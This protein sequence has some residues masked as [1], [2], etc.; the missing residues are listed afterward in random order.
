[1]SSTASA[2]PRS[3]RQTSQIQSGYECF[4]GPSGSDASRGPTPSATRR[5]TAFVNGTARSSRARRTSSTDSFTAAYC[6]TPSRY[7]SWYAPSLSA[8]RT[9]A[10]SLR[11]GR[12][13]SVSIAWSSVRTRC[14][15]PNA[16][17][18]A[19]ARSRASRPAEALRSALSA[20]ASSSKTRRSTSYAAPRAGEITAGRAGTR[21][22]SCAACPRAAP[23]PGRALRPPPGRSRS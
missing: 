1:M 6:G 23:R 22:R 5:S 7:A 8:A 11:T 19:S 10:S 18:R 13:P 4:S 14:T 12:L 21:R 17:C 20:Y 9:G 15:A 2:S 3:R 16:S